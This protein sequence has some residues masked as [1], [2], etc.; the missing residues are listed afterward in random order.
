[1]K[2]QLVGYGIRQPN[3]FALS[4]LVG[5]KEKQ[6]AEISVSSHL[7]EFE[8]AFY[9]FISRD[10]LQTSLAS[11]ENDLERIM[12]DIEGLIEAS[13]Q[14]ESLK[15]KRKKELIEEKTIVFE[16]LTKQSVG[17][18]E[19][20]VSQELNE[21]VFYI[22]QRVFLRF[23]DFF[24]ESFNPSVLQDDGRNLKKALRSSL[25]EF[26]A[27]IGY[28]F[29]QELRATLLRMDSFLRKQLEE[30]HNR[31]LDQLIAINNQIMITLPEF[32]QDRQIEFVNAFDH[33]NRELF[34]K[35]L[36]TFK[37]PKS[38]F[39]KNEK[40][41]MMEELHQLLQMPA[42]EYLQNEGQKL[43]QF[44]LKLLHHLFEQKISHTKLEMDA[45]YDRY[46]SLLDQ[47]GQSEELLQVLSKIK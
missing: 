1:V 27:S 47:K 21:L 19:T 23:N 34:Q 18:V 36:S 40:K 11:A 25:E 38:F 15:M 22:K 33:L 2:D 41:M 39:E 45:F 42:D 20:R 6:K 43:N 4:S 16:L 3:L 24:K 28:D 12:K 32:N 13:N 7:N 29:A 9:Q 30:Y 46:I 37:N 14:D 44:Y 8:E 35:A 26:L 5:L 31:L 10:L 17:Y